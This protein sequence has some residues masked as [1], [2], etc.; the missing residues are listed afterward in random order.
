MLELHKLDEVFRFFELGGE[1]LD[2]GPDLAERH[3]G[4]S[5]VVMTPAVMI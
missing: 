5:V 1:L 3:V 2:D 4:V